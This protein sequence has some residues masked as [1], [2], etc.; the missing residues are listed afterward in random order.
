MRARKRYLFALAAVTVGCGGFDEAE[1][2]RR[3]AA[4][5]APFK[6][7]L[8]STLVTALEDGPAAAIE[9][10]AVEAP[11][12]AQRA[13]HDG[14]RLGRSSK[15]LRNLGNTA[16]EWVEPFL[17]GIDGPRVVDLGNGRAGY[18][19][20]IRVQALCTQCH[21]RDLKPEITARLAERYPLDRATGY[22]EGDFRGVFWVEL[23]TN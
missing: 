14:M 6:T 18:V 2:A 17:G 13:S 9:A 1:M 11:R 4:A 3:G 19:E 8:K 22:A 5:L 12:I 23:E 7:E 20:P 16:A 21:G 15:R 10:C